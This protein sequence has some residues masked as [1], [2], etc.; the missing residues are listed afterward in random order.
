L[1][2]PKQ[3]LPNYPP[4]LARVIDLWA[5]LPEALRSALAGWKDLAEPIR[6]AVLALVGTA[7]KQGG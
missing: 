4:G 1:T 3:K 2:T 6:A 7:G 5:E